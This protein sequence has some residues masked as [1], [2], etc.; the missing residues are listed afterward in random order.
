M[1][2]SS[3]IPNLYR[4]GFL[5]SRAVD[6]LP[7]LAARDSSEESHYIVAECRDL[8]DKVIRGE[9]FVVGSGPGDINNLRPD[10]VETFSFVLTRD[11]SLKKLAQQEGDL[12]KYLDE[13]RATLQTLEMDPRSVKEEDVNTAV[14]FFSK[15]ADSLLDAAREGATQYPSD[16]PT[17][18]AHE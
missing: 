17:P 18:V 4:Y 16:E 1:R 15:I 5:T 6:L 12:R 9:E 7:Q 10:D 11:S 13:I 3:T 8:V 2:T 14:R